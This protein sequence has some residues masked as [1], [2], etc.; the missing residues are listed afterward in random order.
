MRSRTTIT[1]TR[2]WII[3]N[4]SSSS[5]SWSMATRMIVSIRTGTTTRM[6]EAIRMKTVTRT[7]LQMAMIV[8]D[9]LISSGLK[10]VAP[11]VGDIV[12]ATKGF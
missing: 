9:V 7:G 6:A 1:I 3:T 5:T 11:N 8:A 12:R 4:T 2:T 10:S